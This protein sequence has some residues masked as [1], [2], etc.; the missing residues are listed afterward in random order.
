MTLLQRL[1]IYQAERFPLAKTVPLLACFSAA[2]ITLSA[3]LSGR[4]LPALSA[5]LVGFFLVFI[6]FFQMRVADEV[7]DGEDDAKYR[8]ERAIPRGLV[9]LRLI[10]SLGAVTI[11]LGILLAQIHGAGL[12]WLLAL[13]WAWLTAMTFEFGVP[14]W[15]KARPVFYLLSHMAIMPLI[16][17]LLTGIEWLPHGS[18]TPALWI[19]IALSFSNGCVLEIGRKLWSPENERIGVDTYSKLWGA[20]RAAF[21]WL[22]FV[23]V[24]AVLLIGVGVVTGFPLA[25]ILI[26][27]LGFLFCI[28]AARRYAINPTPK[29]EKQMDTVAGLWV[30]GCYATAGFLPLALGGLP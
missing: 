29:T 19:F 26:G 10:V 5:Y 23:G 3:V 22:G 28:Y 12:I 4:P 20:K 13:T 14:A 6:L 7:K 15:L 1:W 30:F 8:P 27:L 9:T 18:A 16:D 11:P 17:L 24:S 2:S 21:I 25:F